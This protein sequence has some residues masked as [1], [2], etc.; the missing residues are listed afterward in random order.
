MSR[1]EKK[2]KKKKKKEKASTE[3]S[4]QSLARGVRGPQRVVLSSF[5]SPSVVGLLQGSPPDAAPRPN[6]AHK[7]L[8]GSV[9]RLAPYRRTSETMEPLAHAP[10]SQ[11]RAENFNS[12]FGLMGRAREA[13]PF[14]CAVSGRAATMQRTTE[15]D[16]EGE[17]KGGRKRKRTGRGDGD[18]T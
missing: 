3:L 18:K 4:G 1:G 9:G 12:T 8:R 6:L 7:E 5:C 2:R 14:G 11:S 15:V 13:A 17:T 10:Q 16:S